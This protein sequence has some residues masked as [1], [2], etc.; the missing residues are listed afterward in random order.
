M[1][2]NPNIVIK[3]FTFCLLLIVHFFD[4]QN[5]NMIICLLMKKLKLY[6]LKT[7]LLHFLKFYFIRNIMYNIL[8]IRVQL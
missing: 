3:F 8:C 5:V 7:N 1:F 6:Y 2:L 4:T